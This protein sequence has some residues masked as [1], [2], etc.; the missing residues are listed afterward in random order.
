MADLNPSP[1][2]TQI[3][4]ASPTT[5]L[6]A[7]TGNK[8]LVQFGGKTIGLCQSCDIQEDYSPEPCSGMGDISVTEYVPTM[9]RYTVHVEEM[10]LNAG[11]M[12]SAGI[13]PGDANDM[14]KGNVFEI[15]FVSTHAGVPALDRVIQGCS[16]ASGNVQIRK[17][18]IVVAS[19]VF[20]AIA[21]KGVSI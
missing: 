10:V 6:F 19:A 9:A 20:N 4:N 8:I 11:S 15:S 16:Y 17:H 18:A 2:N 12:R 14:L 13:I 1:A 5:R 21:V 3:G 7:K